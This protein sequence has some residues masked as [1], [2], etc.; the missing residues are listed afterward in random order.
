M[1]EQCGLNIWPYC[2]DWSATGAMLGGFG[3]L[4]GAAAIVVAAGNFQSWTKRER[5]KADRERAIEIAAL[6]HEGRFV[7][8]QIRS[9]LLLAGELNRAKEAIESDE[10]TQEDAKN[11]RWITRRVMITRIVDQEDYWV[12]VFNSLPM[13]KAVFGEH[14]YDALFS[15]LKAR[16]KV[17]AAAEMYPSLDGVNFD[18]TQVLFRRKEPESEE[19]KSLEAMLDQAEAELD[20]LMAPYVSDS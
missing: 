19:A 18:V 9:P 10:R 14:I 5:Y 12:K 4:L 3:A 11:Q 1:S 8:E 17:Y 15:I 13:A 2:I 7:L 20:R 6:F 16:Q